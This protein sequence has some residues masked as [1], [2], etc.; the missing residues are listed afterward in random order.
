MKAKTAAYPI[1]FILTFHS[2]FS[3]LFTTKFLKFLSCLGLNISHGTVI[4]LFSSYINGC[5]A[6]KNENTKKKLRLQRAL[7]FIPKITHSL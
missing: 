1:F 6:T 2:V 5:F 3:Y 4:K 7:L